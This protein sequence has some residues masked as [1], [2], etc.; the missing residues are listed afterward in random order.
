MKPIYITTLSLALVA[1]C[2]S[3][4]KA[5]NPSTFNCINGL[6]APQG[7]YMTVS[8]SSVQDYNADG[9]PDTTACA[10]DYSKQIICWRIQ[11]CQ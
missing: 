2:G 9:F 4:T 3:V 1:A 8:I 7:Q 6:T 5:D 10:V 11:P